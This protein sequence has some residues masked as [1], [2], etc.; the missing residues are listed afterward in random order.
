MS[1]GLG[2]KGPPWIHPWVQWLCIFRPYIYA[3]IYSSTLTKIGDIFSP[4]ILPSTIQLGTW[5]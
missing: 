3:L 2:P 5:T 1:G 4:N